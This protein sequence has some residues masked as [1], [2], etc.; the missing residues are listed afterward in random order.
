M[1][2]IITYDLNKTGQ[3]YD[4]LYK[5]IISLGQICHALQNLWL[6]DTNYNIDTVRDSLR[7]VIDQNDYVFIAQ[8]FRGSYSAYMSTEAI[9]WL[10]R[11]F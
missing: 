10:N 7:S 8:L 6:L 5:K 1:V 9:D 3:D 4:A 11:R 2:Y